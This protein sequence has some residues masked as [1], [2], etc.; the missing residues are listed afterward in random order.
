MNRRISAH[1]AFAA[2]PLHGEGPWWDVREQRLLWVDMVG[3]SVHIASPN[4]GSDRTIATPEY[5]GVAVGRQAGG[6]LVLMGSG[7]ASL[8]TD[9]GE[10]QWLAHVPGAGQEVKLNDGKCDPVGRFV[11]GSK[12]SIPD[13]AP[14]SL[15]VLDAS[16]SMRVILTGLVTSN[17]MSWTD[18][19]TTLY[20]VD[21]GTRRIR[22]LHYDV[23]A[24]AI[25]SEDASIEV[26][27]DAAGSPDGMTIDVDGCLWVAMHGGGVVRRY[28]PSGR[29]DS[30]V[31]LPVAGATSCAFG[32]PDLGDLYITTSPYSLTQEQRLRQPYAGSVFVCR[33]GVGGRPETYFAG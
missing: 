5:T 4:T 8:D 26:P 22:V 19:G 25:T 17:G 16:L 15:F 3:P 33:P 21:S 18:D 14:G 2:S 27:H 24:G 28:T 10:I 1:L 29:L 31:S 7:V 13:V 23:D 20:L 32:G 11:C 6:L 30:I 12:S 9:S